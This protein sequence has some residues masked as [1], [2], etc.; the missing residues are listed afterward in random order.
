MLDDVHLVHVSAGDRGSYVVDGRSVL[1]RRPCLQPVAEYV[2]AADWRDVVH[3]PHTTCGERQL[4]TRLRWR[5]PRT[6][7]D[8]LGKP[9]AQV[10]IR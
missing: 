7:T 8:C 6:A 10:E 4:G 9:V 2:V 3:R 1:R 5:R